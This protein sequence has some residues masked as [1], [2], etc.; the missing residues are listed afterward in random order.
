MKRGRP[1]GLT[2]ALLT[3]TVLY[4]LY[5]LLEALF[6]MTVTVRLNAAI[7]PRVVLTLVLGIGFLLI[8]IPAWQGRPPQIRRV[9]MAAVGGLMVI[10]LAFSVVDLT[11]NNTGGAMMDSLS[12]TR[13]TTTLISLLLQ[14]FVPLYVI[15]YLN[16]HPSRQYY[17]AD[18]ISES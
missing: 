17:D 10:N 4:G 8:L 1:L 16:R 6:L 18:E 2:L 9:L 13:Q 7:A 15:W 11:G 3:C 5:P 14:I 12:Q